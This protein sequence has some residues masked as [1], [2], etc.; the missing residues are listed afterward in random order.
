MPCKNLRDVEK[1][2][3]N[4]NN[5]KNRYI[6][7]Q[8]LCGDEHRIPRIFD[9]ATS[10][11]SEVSGRRHDSI[12]LLPESLGKRRNGVYLLKAILQRK[13]LDHGMESRMAALVSM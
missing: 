1:I 9:D 5:P 7:R 3:T 6:F 12:Q 10:D 13:I 8:Q 11:R 2:S 4:L